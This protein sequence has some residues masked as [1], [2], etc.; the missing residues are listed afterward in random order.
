MRNFIFL[1]ISLI[2]F[3]G[4]AD[5]SPRLSSPLSNSGKIDEVK[6]NQNGIIAEVGKLKQGLELQNSQLKDVQQGIL[7]LNAA[8]SKNENSGVQILQGDG[9]LIMIFSIVTIG[10]LLYYKNKSDN[11]QKVCNILAKEVASIND[12]ILN[13][14]IL[15]SAVSSKKGK[16]VYNMLKKHIRS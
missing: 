1:T 8:I 2:V 16:D 13:E 10:M 3:S 11:S 6:S 15:R 9:A 5:I 12:P 14:K 4:C 7:N